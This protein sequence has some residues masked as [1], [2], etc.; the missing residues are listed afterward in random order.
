MKAV[1]FCL[2]LC[3]LVVIF[4]VL[5][6]SSSKQPDNL[7]EKRLLVASL[8]LTDLTLCSEARYTR[9]PSQADVFAPFQDYPGAFEHFPT[10][11][12]LPPV[13]NGLVGRVKFY[14][15]TSKAP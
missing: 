6:A 15:A 9:H 13:V 8:G 7:A 1:A 10:G 5:L 3:L 12:L 14:P 4:G 11:S 2:F